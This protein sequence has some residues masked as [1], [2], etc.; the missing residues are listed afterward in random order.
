MTFLNFILTN[1]Y[2]FQIGESIEYFET[3]ALL[4]LVGTSQNNQTKL[5]KSKSDNEEIDTHIKDTNN[6][7]ETDKTCPFDIVENT[8][9]LAE[10]VI[11]GKIFHLS[12]ISVNNTQPE[13]EEYAT[14]F[15][16]NTCNEPSNGIISVT[17]LDVEEVSITKEDEEI[18]A[19]GPKVIFLYNK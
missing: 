5:V 2:Y 15:G 8:E 13:T 10:S 7:N 6:C 12:D 1:S 18:V 3:S 9:N 11:S 17:V 14:N 4:N 19:E 16:M